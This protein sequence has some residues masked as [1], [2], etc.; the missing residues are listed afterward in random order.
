MA[1]G[2]Q[3][4]FP[5]IIG[6]DASF[7]GELTFEKGLRLVG[8]F[9]GRITTAGRLHVAEMPMDELRIHADSVIVHQSAS[10][11]RQP[12]AVARASTSRAQETAQIARAASGQIWGRC[13]GSSR[14]G[15]GRR[16]DSAV[17]RASG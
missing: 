10:E 16:Q 6:P 12:G 15:E 8:K 7:K 2:N 11:N 3:Q 4:D 17:V 1:D 5:T 14:H 13:S 9:D